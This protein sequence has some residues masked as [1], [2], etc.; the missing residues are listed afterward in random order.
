[1]W[2]GQGGSY[3][4]QFASLRNDIRK[5]I[6]KTIKKEVAKSCSSANDDDCSAGAAAS[7]AAAQGAQFLEEVYGEDPN[8]YI[9]KDSIPCYGCSLP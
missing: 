7:P 3:D 6:R 4:A 8:A 2:G 5:D 9:K 1:V